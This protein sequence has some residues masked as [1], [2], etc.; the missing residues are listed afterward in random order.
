MPKTNKSEKVQNMDAASR[1][2]TDSIYREISDLAEINRGA[3]EKNKKAHL[4]CALPKIRLQIV[5]RTPVNT[6]YVENAPTNKRAP[7]KDPPQI[8]GKP[9]PSQ[10]PKVIITK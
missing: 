6:L 8:A 5:T 4:K 3:P 7:F 9:T 10:R 2:A 1:Q